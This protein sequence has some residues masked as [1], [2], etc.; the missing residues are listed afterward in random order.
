MAYRS[1]DFR[2]DPFGDRPVGWL[3]TYELAAI[4]VE[5]TADKCRLWRRVAA[6]E[7]DQPAP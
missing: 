2:K 3:R 1:R 4:I 6:V 5:Q 7:R